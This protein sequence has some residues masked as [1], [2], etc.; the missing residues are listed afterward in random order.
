MQDCFLAPI[1]LKSGAVLRKAKDLL[2]PFSWQERRPFLTENFLYLPKQ[3]TDHTSFSSLYDVKRPVS[4]EYCSG[5]GQWIAEK[6]ASHPEKMWVAVEMDFERARKIWV[7]IDRFSLSNLLVV[8]GEALTFS[9][10]Y[11]PS[12]SVEEVYVNFPD[13]WPKKRH[14][15]HRLFQ[16]PFEKE[17]ER[18]L[19]KGGRGIFVTD[20][21]LYAK[22]I[23]DL[24]SPWK[25]LY[26][27]MEW[28]S[29][30]SSYFD[31]LWR[32]KGLKIHYLQVERS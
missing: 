24:F 23:R 13:P 22:Q 2:L 27:G 15:K 10:H 8:C 6:A 16:A 29:Y 32:S 12:G 28:E 14:A 3:F 31:S 7:K 26:E 21:P 20:D 19:V 30:G 9:E 1:S 11:V 5:N 4:I 18:Q 17:L 25:V